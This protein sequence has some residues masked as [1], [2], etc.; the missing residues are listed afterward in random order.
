MS[1]HISLEQVT[2]E[3]L[4]A[5]TGFVADR[6]LTGGDGPTGTVSGA[7]VD[8]AYEYDEA[9]GRLELDVEKFPRPFEDLLPEDRVE[10]FTALVRAAMEGPSNLLGRPNEPGVYNY[11]L[12][13]IENKCEEILTYGSANMEHGSITITTS[14]YDVGKTAQAFDARSLG[15]SIVG[16]GGRVVYVVGS[17]S[18]SMNI[19][20]FLNGVG[21][22]SFTVGL[23]GG[24]A[25]LYKVTVTNTDPTLDS[26]TY[27]EP[28][29][30]IERAS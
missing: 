19:D 23:T 17:G 3:M 20:F 2:P 14:R 25:Y 30:K 27:L 6:G 18:P 12:P 26:Y 5:G 22:H 1:V 10:R 24:N 21:E 13:T 16:V 7:H 4:A 15:G 29:I 11:V 9:S 28:N 8:L